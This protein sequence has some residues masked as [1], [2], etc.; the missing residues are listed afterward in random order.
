MELDFRKEPCILGD[1]VD[2]M[3]IAVFTL[4]AEGNFVAWSDGAARITGYTREEVVGQP[5]RLL[6]G[7]NCKGF[8]TLEDLLHSTDE[9]ADG[10]CNQECKIMAKNGHELYIHGNVRLL[11][12]DRNETVG[13]VG[14]F[15]DM[16]SFVLANEKIA[17]LER[18]AHAV[19][20]LEHLV[21]HSQSMQEVFRRLLLAADSDVTVLLTG[22]SGTGKELA[23]SAIHARSARRDAP[24]LGVN[25]S[26]IP[27]S[28]LESELFGHVKGAFTGAVRDKI[29]LFQAADGGT[30]LLDEIG[31]VSP[32][33]QVKLLRVLQQREIRRVGDERAFPIDV[34][35]IT[36]TNKDLRSLMAAN[37]VREDF[38][39]RIRVFEIH[40]PPLRRRKDDIPL[41]AEHF[42]NSLNGT[43]AKS[44]DGITR[45]A[46]QRMMDY[47]WPGNVRELRNAIEHAFVTVDS[48]RL[49]VADL[50]AEIRA[51]GGPPRQ[52]GDDGQ[53]SVE[54][55]AERRQI[56]AALEQT[57]WSR[58]E[59]SKLLGFSRVTLWKKM[60][61]YDIQPP[62]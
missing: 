30:L 29:G 41:L 32:A 20:H 1:I 60:K 12:D 18:Q 5:C 34:R 58:T 26:A 59:A 19:H 10:I 21:G 4:D 13:A 53:R 7:E 57:N 49:T 38:F 6:E 55:L 25:C 14:T 47:S 37:Q 2:A 11:K 36:A 24:F 61:R 15:T 56:V 23:A 3:A 33:V 17:L 43:R 62:G 22:E 42:I 39:Y 52:G 44:I 48:D 8:A 54:E 27:E 31:D 9:S 16:T 50:P 51:G 46:L 28:L 45:E 35:L 40:L